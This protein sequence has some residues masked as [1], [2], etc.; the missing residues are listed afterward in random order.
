MTLSYNGNSNKKGKL[1]AELFDSFPFIRDSAT[2]TSVVWE[3]AT[4]MS[5]GCALVHSYKVGNHKSLVDAIFSATFCSP[6][7]IKT[8]VREGGSC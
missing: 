1:F 7:R 8:S 4:E 6:E 5:V 3:S 2:P